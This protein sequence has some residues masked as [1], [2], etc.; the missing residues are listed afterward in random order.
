MNDR[1]QPPAR[2]RAER[3]A[4]EGMREGEMEAAGPVP[5][6]IWTEPQLRSDEL[7]FAGFA[8]A[9]AHGITVACGEGKDCRHGAQCSAPERLSA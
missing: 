9:Q 1:T 5:S 3:Q 2:P 6:L 4:P 8:Q 7:G